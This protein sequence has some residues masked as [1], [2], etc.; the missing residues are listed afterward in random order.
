MITSS[1]KQ[2]GLSLVEVLLASVLGLLSLSLMVNTIVSTQRIITR[3]SNQ[4]YLQ[5]SVADAMRFLTDDIRR[6]GF[7]GVYG[8]PVRF[9]DAEGIVELSDFMANYVYRKEGEYVYTAVKIDEKQ[10]KLMLCILISDHLPSFGS[11]SR[12]YS[13]FDA[14]RIKVTAFKIDVKSF[15]SKSANRL[16]KL[17]LTAEIKGDSSL[18]TSMQAYVL[19]RA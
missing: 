9:A 15:P 5:Q 19:P 7:N 1:A 14:Q 6:A 13:F 3:E 10:H 18:F 16:L 8:Q 2:K 17:T 12:F 4:L 11:C